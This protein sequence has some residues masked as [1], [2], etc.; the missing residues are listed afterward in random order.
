MSRTKAQWKALKEERR[1][2][3]FEVNGF[4][5]G[6]D[7]VLCQ[8]PCGYMKEK[9]HRKSGNERVCTSG[10][11]RETVYTGSSVCPRERE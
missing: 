2:K 4:G 10:G 9:N 6:T 8:A 5:D 3:E 7:A 1:Q 11:K